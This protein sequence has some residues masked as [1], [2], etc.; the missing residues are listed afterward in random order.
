MSTRVIEVPNTGHVPEHHEAANPCV[1]GLQAEFFPHPSGARRRV[2]GGDSA[3]HRRR[4]SIRR[5]YR[6][7]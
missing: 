6:H 2:P 7:R 4:V 3:A 5:C 1:M